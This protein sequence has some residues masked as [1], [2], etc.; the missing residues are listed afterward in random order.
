MQTKKRMLLGR[1]NLLLT[2]VLILTMTLTMAAPVAAAPGDVLITPPLP[3]ELPFEVEL[4]LASTG[5]LKQAP[6][7]KEMIQLLKDPYL[8]DNVTQTAPGLERRRSFRFDA[9]GNE[10]P[11]PDLN[12]WSLDRNVLTN[13]PFRLRSSDGEISWD[14]PGTL[15]DPDEP[16]TPPTDP[17]YPYPGVQ[18]VLRTVIGE[19]VA[20]DADINGIVVTNGY[21]VVRNPEADPRIVDPAPDL[22]DPR[23]P[24]DGTIVAAPA[25]FDGLLHELV[26]D[27][28]G[29]LVFDDAN[30]NG[31]FDVEFDAEG[32]VVS[33][34][35]PEYEEVLTFEDEIPINE[36]DFFRDPLDASGLTG[37]LL[38]VPA[39]YRGRAGAEVLGKALFWD[40]QVGSDGVQACG[41]CHFAAGVDNRTK[42]QLNPNI[43]GPLGNNAT[44]EI[45]GPN[46]EVVASNF[47]FHK[48]NDPNIVG[49]PLLN[50]SNVVSDS[51]DV[52]SSM[53]VSEF[54]LFVDIPTIGA[55]SFGPAVN[56]VM[57]LLPDI[58]TV[59][60]D[61]VPVNQGLRRI[62][63]RHTPTMHA[64]AF[65][66]DNF[67]DGR[68]RHD[69]N[70]G[71]VFGAADPFFHIFVDPGDPGGGPADSL[72]AANNGYFRP[73]LLLTADPK[74][75]QPVRILFSSLASQSVGPPLSNFEMSFDGRNW[76]K[77][78]K[79][80]LQG[81]GTAARPNVTPLA[82]QLVA[83]DDSILGP[84]SNQGGALAIA[85]GR[86]TAPGM[87][88]LAFT[89]PELIQLAFRADLWH[90]LTGHLNGAAV[91]TAGFDQLN[92]VQGGPDPFDGFALTIASG[93]V[94][95]SDTNQFTQMEANFS[96]F[97]GLSVQAYEELLIPDDT[98]FDKFMD[99]NP[100]AADAVSQPGEQ[101]NLPPELIPT[102]VGPIT[103]IPDDPSTP[104]YDGF[105]PDEIFG[106]D[107]FSGANLSAALI[108]DQAIDPRSGTNRNPV[109]TAL[110]YGVG[111]N[112]FFRTARCM[113][114]HLGP[115]QSDHTSNVLAGLLHSDTE[116]ELP[117]S[118][119]PLAAVEPTGPFR[120]VSGFL[121]AEEFEG[122]AQ[123][124]IEIEARDMAI[125]NALV[126]DPA[127]PWPDFL[128]REIGTMN[129]SAFQDNGIYNIGLRPT[130]NDIGRGDLDPF[131]WP[132]LIAELAMKNLAGTDFSAPQTP[133]DP[134]ALM[135]NFDPALGFGGGLFEEIG[136]GAL[137]PGT[138]YTVQ[139]INPGLEMEPITP[140]MP[141]YIAPWINNMPAGEGH[142]LIDELAMVPNTITYFHFGEFWEWQFGS[143]IHA[144]IY[145]PVLY[146]RNG[147]GPAPDNPISAGFGDIN[148]NVVSASANNFAPNLN[149]TWPFAN[150]VAGDG[151]F[152][153]PHL[154]NVELTGPYFHTGSFLTLRQ[155]VDFYMRGGDFPISNSENRD[156]NMINIEEQAFGLGSTQELFDAGVFALDGLP[157]TVAMYDDM[158]DTDHPFSPEPVPPDVTAGGPREDE[159][160]DVSIS[161]VKFLLAMTDARVKFERAPFDRPEMFVPIDGTAPE[162]GPTALDPTAGGRTFLLANS[163][164]NPLNLAPVFRHL[165]AVGA[166]GRFLADGV[167]PDPLPNFLGVL[168]VPTPGVVDHFD[169]VRDSNV[170]PVANPDA[171]TTTDAVAS[172]GFVVAAPGVL[173]NDSD[174]DG[175]ALSA[176]LVTAPVGATLVLNLDGSFTFTTAVAGVYTFTY[177]AMDNYVLPL[178][179]PPATVTITVTQ[180]AP[181]APAAPSNV[182]ATLGAG[183]SVNVTWTDNSNNETGFAIQ[184]ATDSAFTTGV[185]LSPAGAN[186]TTF[187]TGNLVA[188]SYYFRVNA[189]N[190]VGASAW[191]NATPFPI[192]VSAPPPPAAPA[193]PSNVTATS[194]AGSSV[195]LTWTDNSNNETGFAIQRATDSTFTTG[196]VLLPVGANVTTFNTG[197]LPPGTYYF[198]VRSFTF[199]VGASAWVNATPFPIT[200]P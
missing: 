124:A 195:T 130:N 64:A 146:T 95:H 57:P 149:G 65:N 184:R 17:L 25:F 49:E 67:W 139:S 70:G 30:G 5:A 97:F 119:P 37:G 162:N 151:A 193:A 78:G 85:M 42:G 58:G 183:T 110:G 116:I 194:G 76:A 40:M 143:D 175:D 66:F 167:T 28:A 168:S 27:A 7:W 174:P 161:L 158:P 101:G 123:D 47:P 153:V 147:W 86:P 148:P 198:R 92:P 156:P 132:L 98:P 145:D 103:L 163:T 23:I 200:V 164:G 90:N 16:V 190:G 125:V 69:F 165:P 186:V 104:W 120:F 170:A 160:E 9:A 100:T 154:R 11:M 196:S 152:K 32:N 134:V 106:F 13:E 140:M 187:N 199:Q 112:P 137:Y 43:D 176:I 31:I 48:L 45:A 172:A 180:A 83:V 77:I 20:V 19:L 21:L 178:T 38:N 80:L 71:S 135:P 34:D 182:T 15:F 93:G 197:N 141:P 185:V 82:N 22:A 56:G 12:V 117:P 144:T 4:E 89:Y 35:T 107:I 46:G 91:G 87:P 63:S 166:G 109:V 60:P 189:F 133:S 157:D 53:G 73:D 121:L 99:A 24:P 177:S 96:L 129:G 191:V 114:C 51:D 62:E 188:G 102:V 44:L 14:I 61:P 88:G 131:G 1:L 33:S 36:T 94:G 74:A 55:A 169:A 75:E 181:A 18:T 72:Q 179:S 26:F 52:M 8:V 171:F 173:A 105:G 136:D 138:A 142:P 59:A 81:A 159:L 126:D 10:L 39:V 113:L 68:A 29:E 150:R 115:E 41:Q 79:K 127:T 2:A 128:N 54:K 84:F 118:F 50:P 122:T 155:V 192:T 3:P 108:G 6:L 111:S